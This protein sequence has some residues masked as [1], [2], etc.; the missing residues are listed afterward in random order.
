[1]S[2]RYAQLMVQEF[3]VSSASVAIAQN[4]IGQSTE[5][6]R[7]LTA[8]VVSRRFCQLL[9]ANP[10]AA[11]TA[12][13]RGESFR[14]NAD[15][16]RRVT[17]IRASSLQDFAQQLLKNAEADPDTARVYET[18]QPPVRIAFSARGMGA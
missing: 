12:G 6:N 18:Y 17:A 9:L 3:G 11:L 7:L 5:I 1:M 16:M 15:E 8:A 4:A 13:Y 2:T 14:L 10:V